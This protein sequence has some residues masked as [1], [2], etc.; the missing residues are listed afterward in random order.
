VSLPVSFSISLSVC[1]SL[2]FSLSA[3]F[4]CFITLCISLVS[5]PLD[6]LSFSLWKRQKRETRK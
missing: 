3:V 1:F 4:H 6:S 2:F 5:F